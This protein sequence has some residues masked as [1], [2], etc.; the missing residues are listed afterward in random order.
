VTDKMREAA[1][2]QYTMTAHNYAE[3]PI[4]SRDWTLYWRGWQ[5]ALAQPEQPKPKLAYYQ[6]HEP[7]H[8]P[9]CGCGMPAQPEQR[10]EAVAYARRLAVV[11]HRDHFA[12]DAPKWEPYDDLYGLL[13]QID[14]MICGMTR[15]APPA[16]AVPPGWKLVPER[17][18]P[19]MGHAGDATLDDDGSMQEMWTN[20]LAAAPEVKP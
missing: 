15:A 4:G 13:S 19:H 18:T 2:H 16:P 12:K 7:P 10:G 1:E 14:N 9:T 20:I 17:L 11:L 3:A 8:C 5:A 6:T